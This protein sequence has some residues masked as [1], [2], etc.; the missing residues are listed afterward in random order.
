MRPGQACK[1]LMK[2]PFAVWKL[3]LLIIILTST[4]HRNVVRRNRFVFHKFWEQ[5]KKIYIYN[6][7]KTLSP[8]FP[9][10]SPVS[11][12]NTTKQQRTFHVIGTQEENFEQKQ[13]YLKMFTKI[14][15]N[16]DWR[17]AF[18][19]NNNLADKYWFIK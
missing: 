14:L 11:I 15:K 3:E 7:T 12:C 2:L 9:S 13:K 17:N 18:Q 4:T 6:V 16:L 5:K 10:L 19:E 8:L 1:T